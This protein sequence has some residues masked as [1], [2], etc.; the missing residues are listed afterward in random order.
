MV[1]SASRDNDRVIYPEDFNR[2][3]TLLESVEPKMPRAFIGLGKARYAEM[4]SHLFDYL[5]RVGKASR[6]NILDKFN[7]DLD[8]YTL[9][10]IMKTLAARKV[11]SIEYL[12]E[13]GEYIYTLLNGGGE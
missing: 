1:C 2:A 10:I 7:H 4:T 9:G 12:P 5:T 3:I 8:E 11:V 6:S 13:K